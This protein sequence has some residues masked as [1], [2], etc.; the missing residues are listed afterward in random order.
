MIFCCPCTNA[1]LLWLQSIQRV[2]EWRT[3]IGKAA[4]EALEA[5]WAL[6]AKYNDPEARKEYVEFV[7]GPGLPFLYGHVEHQDRDDMIQVSRM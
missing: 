2:Y 7:L 5:H 3:I 6:D 4:L 1:L